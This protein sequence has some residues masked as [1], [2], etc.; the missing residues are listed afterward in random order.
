MPTPA[1]EVDELVVLVWAAPMAPYPA[2]L[3]SGPRATWMRDEVP[4]VSVRTLSGLP[5]SRVRRPVSD[6]REMLRYTGAQ[7]GHLGTVDDRALLL[8]AYGG[9]ASAAS[10]TGAEEPWQRAVA[11]VASKSIVLASTGVRRWESEVVSRRKNRRSPRVTESAGHLTVHQPSTLSNSLAIQLAAMEHVATGPRRPGM[12]FVTSSA[13]V[14]L[15]RLRA[16]ASANCDGVVIGGSNALSDPRLDGSVLMSG[17]CQYFSWDAIRLI[18]E[19]ADFDHGRLNDEAMTAWLVSHDLAWRDPGIV[20]S[21]D[22]VTAGRCPLCADPSRFVV[23]CTSHG[24]REKE[25]MFMARLHHAHSL[26]ASQPGP[27]PDG[28]RG[29]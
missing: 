16:W 19:S 10:R 25:A 11:H 15:A 24:S 1:A 23:R 29:K 17:F 14:D 9:L 12:M 6:M 28:G 13:Y 2:L 26:A 5:L 21:T 27:A 18:S 20:W 4:G 3:Q 22:D 8:R 7:L